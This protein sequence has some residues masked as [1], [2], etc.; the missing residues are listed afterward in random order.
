MGMYLAFIANNDTNRLLVSNSGDGKK[1]QPSTQVG[2]ESSKRAPAISFI[3]S[4][5]RGFTLGFVAN[6][7]SN[8]LLVSQSADGKTWSPNAQVQSQSSKAAPALAVF[9]NK[10]WI[11]FVA[12]DASNQ[13]LVS[14]S[15]DGTTWSPSTQVQHQSSKAAPALAVFDSKLWIAF[16]AND[17][18]NQ[19]LVSHSAGG[20]TWSPSIQVQNQSSKANPALLALA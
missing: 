6:D 2:N 8:Q 7:A 18:S 12:N 17:A 15:A 9:E 3:S 10:L 19:L 11:A 1:W 20:K 5:P 16:V 13:L 14:H 4:G